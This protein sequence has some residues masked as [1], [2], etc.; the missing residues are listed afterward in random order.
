MHER[1]LA[2]AQSS[3]IRSRTDYSTKFKLKTKTVPV[4]AGETTKTKLKL[5]K[6]KKKQKQ[7]KKLLRSDS[8]RKGSKLKLT[9][10]ASN[11]LGSSDKLKDRAKLKG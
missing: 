7:L 8:A 10:S 2:W 1:L 5:R 4:G 9:V 11:E 3:V 6:N